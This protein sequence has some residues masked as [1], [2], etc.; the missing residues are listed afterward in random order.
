MP[1]VESS[2]TVHSRSG[3]SSGVNGISPGSCRAAHA[4]MICRVAKST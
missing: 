2:A 1:A 3:F 4:F